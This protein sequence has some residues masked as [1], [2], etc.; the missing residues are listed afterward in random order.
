MADFLRFA[1]P[2]ERRTIS[3]EDVGYYNALLIGAVYDLCDVDIAEAKSFIT[4]LEACIAKYPFLSV[5]VKDK[6]TEKPYY[7]AVSSL[8]L[9]DHISIV[10]NVIDIQ[11]DNEKLQ[12]AIPPILDRPWPAELPPWRIVVVPLASQPKSKLSRCFIAFAFSHSLGDG[13]VGHAFHRTFLDAWHRTSLP[14]KT[15][16]FLVSPP[17][18]LTIPPP[19]DTPSRLPISWS[20]LLSPLLNVYLPKY[21][22]NMLGLRVGASTVDAGTWTGAPIFFDPLACSNGTNSRI[23]LLEIPAPLVENALQVSRNHETKLTGTIHQFIVRALRKALPS[24]TSENEI[25]NLVSGTAV[26]MR[27]SIGTPGY[28]W[29]MFVSGHYEVHQLPEPLSVSSEEPTSPLSEQNWISAQIITKGLSDCASR[30]HDQAIGLLRY[31]PSIRNW[32]LGKIGTRR[33]CSYEVSNLLAFDGTSSG[34]ATNEDKAK[35]SKMVFVQP[36]NP[37]SAPLV[38]NVISV[39]GGSLVC[40]V[41]WQAGALG[42][43]LDEEAFVEG[44]CESMR[45][46]FENLV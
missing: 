18:G 17:S 41:S 20:F 5:I 26:D 2:N 25:T 31:A 34:N 30:L 4:P 10:S 39:K 7:E 3:R 23:R 29:G 46:D 37:L 28:T 22:G 43:A 13:M 11:G 36:G 24:S 12:K 35:I 33:D 21:V 44:V 32:T 9:E 45:G 27:A 16:S 1:S 38:F 14:T 6:D 8:N 42:V 40:A 19:F 15:P